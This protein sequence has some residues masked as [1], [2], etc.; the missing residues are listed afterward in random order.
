MTIPILFS[1]YRPTVLTESA[2]AVAMVT[3]SRERHYFSLVVQ[4]SDLQSHFCSFTFIKKKNRIFFL[5]YINTVG[6]IK[7]VS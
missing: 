3:S 4:D 7:L 1:M 5:G 6:K 2:R